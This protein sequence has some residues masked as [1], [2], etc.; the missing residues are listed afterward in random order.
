MGRVVTASRRTSVWVSKPP[1]RL[2]KERSSTGSVLYRYC[3]CQRP[4]ISRNLSQC[5]DDRGQSLFV[6]TIFTL[7]GNTEDARK[8]SRTF[9]LTFH[10]ASVPKKEIMLS[11]GLTT[12]RFYI[13]KL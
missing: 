7:S 13:W 11:F 8:G 2:S 1:E 6:G 5:K 12:A 9:E 4:Y 10:R 3:F